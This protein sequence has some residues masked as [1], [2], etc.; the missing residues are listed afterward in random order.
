[1][2]QVFSVSGMS[3][4]HCERAITQ[5]LL[6]LDPLAEVQIDRATGQVRVESGEDRQRLSQAIAAEGYDVRPS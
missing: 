4:A 2:E 1:M 6:A 3:C 5:A